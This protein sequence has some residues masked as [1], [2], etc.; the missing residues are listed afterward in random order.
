MQTT[1]LPARRD[2]IRIGSNI[3]I[4]TAMTPIT[5]SNSIIVKPHQ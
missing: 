1:R 2:R 3:E 5:T 4:R